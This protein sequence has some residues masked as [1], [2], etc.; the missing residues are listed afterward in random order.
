M[1][2]T[3]SST[4]GIHHRKSSVFGVSGRISDSVSAPLPRPGGAGNQQVGIFAGGETG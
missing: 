3:D 4:T 2:Y 1:V